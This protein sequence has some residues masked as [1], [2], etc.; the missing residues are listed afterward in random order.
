MKRRTL[1]LAFALGALI[2][3]VSASQVQPA[4]AN[5]PTPSWN[6]V[7]NPDFS[8]G[9][10]TGW[11]TGSGTTGVG[12]YSGSWSTT[13]DH[14]HDAPSGASNSV[15]IGMAATIHT[16]QDG[17][18]LFGE[19]GGAMYWLYQSFGT[20]GYNVRDTTTIYAL[21]CLRENQASPCAKAA[22][23]SL[24]LYK[25]GTDEGW[26]HYIVCD[27]GN[28]GLSGQVIQISS[29]T[30]KSDGSQD[31]F[32]G[33]SD[34]YGAGRNLKSDIHTK[35]G[36][37][38]NDLYITG[39][40]LWSAVWAGVNGE[41]VDGLFKEAYLGEYP[42]PSLT[43]TNTVITD[44]GYGYPTSTCLQLYDGGTP[45][46]EMNANGQFSPFTQVSYRGGVSYTIHVGS[47]SYPT[48][49]HTVG[50]SDVSRGIYSTSGTVTCG[51]GTSA[52]ARGPQLLDGYALTVTTHW[53]P[54]AI[55][56]LSLHYKQFGSDCYKSLSDTSPQATVVVD[57]NTSADLPKE[58]GYTSGVSRVD[59][60]T[61]PSWT[62]IGS[63]GSEDAYY[64][65][66][67]WTTVTTRG[68]TQ[69]HP[70]TVEVKQFGVWNY[71]TTSGTWSDWADAGTAL[72]LSLEAT[73]S[74]STERWHTYETRSWITVPA[75]SAS[76][77]Y[78]HQYYVSL[79]PL[80]QLGRPLNR[81]MNVTYFGDDGSNLAN[82]T[83]EMTFSA[84]VGRWMD[85]G[86][87]LAVSK[88]TGGDTL[89]EQWYCYNWTL[90]GNSRQ[91]TVSEGATYNLVFHHQFRLE[92][93]LLS[94]QNGGCEVYQNYSYLAV[95]D[96]VRGCAWSWDSDTDP[97]PDAVRTF[98]FNWMTPAGQ[99]V[100]TD[101]L[102][103][104]CCYTDAFQVP[105]TYG[106][107][108]LQVVW[109]DG[110][111]I[112]YNKTASFYVC[113]YD[114]RA[115]AMEDLASNDINL[116][117]NLLP[118]GCSNTPSYSILIAVTTGMTS[119]SYVRDLD[120][121][122]GGGLAEVT[123]LSTCF[124]VTGGA[125]TTWAAHVVNLD[126]GSAH[127]VAFQV[128]VYDPLT[129]YTYMNFSSSALLGIGGGADLT[130]PFTPLSS[131][132]R[133][134][135]LRVTYTFYVYDALGI[136]LLGS[137]QQDFG[138]A[139]PISWVMR[140]TGTGAI[141]AV[142]C[143]GE[144]NASAILTHI[145]VS[146]L[147]SSG[148]AHFYIAW[149]NCHALSTQDQANSL[150]IYYVNI[151]FEGGNVFATGCVQHP[152]WVE[153]DTNITLTAET[154]FHP[155]PPYYS[156]MTRFIFLGWMWAYTRF[157]AWVSCN[158]TAIKIN[159]TQPVEVV[160][161]W[162]TQYMIEYT[163]YVPATAPTDTVW[164]S[165]T[166]NATLT[167]MSVRSASTAKLWVDGC[168]F[169]S[170][171]DLWINDYTW[172]VV[173]YSTPNK[174]VMGP[175]IFI[176]QY[177]QKMNRVSNITLQCNNFEIGGTLALNV[178]IATTYF[179]AQWINVT[180]LVV[181]KNAI[182]VNGDNVGW[183][184]IRLQLQNNTAHLMI[185]L[186]ADIGNGTL[187]V[188]LTTYGKVETTTTQ[189]RISSVVAPPEQGHIVS[190]DLTP[191]VAAG[192]LLVVFLGASLSISRLKRR[193]NQ[194]KDRCI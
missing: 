88:E 190:G 53:L 128:R 93:E 175:A 189:V 171:E 183:R 182:L 28:L 64:Y 1:I 139:D 37:S 161:Y 85:V 9:D 168:T 39:I 55:G 77:T 101:I 122:Y 22:G 76:I 118:I 136:N 46:F 159:V 141:K 74:S 104:S 100:H 184:N 153:E 45:Q 114:L 191:I 176:L 99:I 36:L 83:Y 125:S 157:P 48:G 47:Y 51:D 71:Q 61:A 31:V 54:G 113:T 92:L 166:A 103:S 75:F 40:E 50:T 132:W 65:L 87:T 16:H 167:N 18:L 162:R 25:G 6:V 181:S 109:S 3:C 69:S 30:S 131:W 29:I 173:N 163:P 12:A 34:N 56:T 148:T 62:N 160:A 96:W 143:V 105:Q 133:Y 70:A 73:N 180:I 178:T 20:P 156:N 145:P 23:V 44:A 174:Y 172:Y 120:L 19:P 15:F 41:D 42:S 98:V 4:S 169:F 154:P 117:V 127:L 146:L 150:T 179:N 192:G 38:G 59:S 82:G 119:A 134:G 149:E 158:D 138:R 129:G 170:M 72:T 116:T 147:S 126:P 144:V 124:F 193:D 121:V 58:A 177:E 14:A 140:G 187:T 151:T 79:D 27:Q 21:I 10:L 60:P 81:A 108:K 11:Q 80:D 155:K 5:F 68:L 115:Q 137:L 78:I 112:V 24:H 17:I 7:T 94:S 33:I 35:F 188:T 43:M 13:I 194:G 102:Q 110:V 90:C 2:I 123:C 130:M 106:E 111:G 185:P 8:T 89:Q 84:P 66:E 135:L 26:L 86:T 165:Y 186:P 107:W 67:C 95:G 52:T 57:P 91:R 49:D 32:D 152:T 97:R 63:S 142:Y 164:V